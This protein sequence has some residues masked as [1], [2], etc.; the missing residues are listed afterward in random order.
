[1]HDESLITLRAKG[2]S[3]RPLSLQYDA[4]VAFWRLFDIVGIPLL[5]ILVG[6]VMWRVRLSRRRSVQL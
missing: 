5:L 6:L 3:A 2:M 1:M 4:K